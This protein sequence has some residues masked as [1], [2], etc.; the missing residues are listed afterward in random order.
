MAG[1][2]STYVEIKVYKEFIQ[3]FMYSPISDYIDIM[4]IM[5]IEQDVYKGRI[6]EEE[7]KKQRN[8]VI[9][10]AQKLHDEMDEIIRKLSYRK[11]VD[12][13][14]KHAME[15]NKRRCEILQ[16]TINLREA[17]WNKHLELFKYR[18]PSEEDPNYEGE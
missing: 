13:W 4:K 11:D 12:E 16:S 7:G 15:W 2:Y 1:K 5:D 9:E 18:D 14:M 17:Y 3:S 10:N 8:E 6:S